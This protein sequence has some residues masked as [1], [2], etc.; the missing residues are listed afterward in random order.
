M[1]DDVICFNVE[2]ILSYLLTSRRISDS[3]RKKIENENSKNVS[4]VSKQKEA[5]SHK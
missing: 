4:K 2:L 3:I 1:I 5:F